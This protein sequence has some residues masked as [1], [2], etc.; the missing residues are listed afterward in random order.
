VK[1]QA[2]LE[3]IASS[4]LLGDEK[5]FGTVSDHATHFVG[6]LCTCATLPK[7]I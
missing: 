4:A 6:K 3:K 7:L 2:N 5:S 1:I